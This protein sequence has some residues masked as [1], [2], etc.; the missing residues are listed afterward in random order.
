MAAG[1]QRLCDL[2]VLPLS[3]TFAFVATHNHFVLERGAE[4]AADLTPVL[5]WAGWDHAQQARVLGL[6]LDQVRAW[7]PAGG[8]AAAGERDRKVDEVVS[9]RPL[10]T[11]IDA[12]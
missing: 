10:V 12:S 2:S 6:T 11:C 1:L 8:P 5:T 4:R 7:A 3:I 9:E